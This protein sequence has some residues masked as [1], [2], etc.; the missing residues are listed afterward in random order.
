M[1]TKINQNKKKMENNEKNRKALIGLH[2]E[3]VR[4]GAKRLLEALEYDVD[5]AG[6]QEEMEEKASNNNYDAYLMDLNFGIPGSID[7]RPAREVYNIVEPKIKEGSARFLGISGK[8]EAVRAAEVM[9]IP[10]KIK[11]ASLLEYFQ[12]K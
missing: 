12:Y 7:I 11:G 1:K 4:R 6:S 2:D 8:D 10:A 9:G 5:I 3:R